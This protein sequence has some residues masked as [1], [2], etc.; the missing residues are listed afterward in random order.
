M[1]VPLG[2]ARRVYPTYLRELDVHP[3]HM[4]QGLGRR[5]IDFVCEQAVVMSLPQV[6]LTTFA[7]VPWNAPLYRRYGFV[8]LPPRQQPMWLAELRE[9]EDAG[10][11]GRW[12]RLA[13]TRVVR[14]GQRPS[15]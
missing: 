3:D 6:T 15:R 10:E 14:A 13:M 8:E 11:L 7:E 5:L 2:D 9:H 12:P 1:N 4:R